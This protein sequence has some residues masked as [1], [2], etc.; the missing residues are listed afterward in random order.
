MD[1]QPIVD[2]IRSFVQSVDQTLTDRVKEV[3]SLYVQACNEVNQQLRRCEEFLQ[4]GLRSEAVHLAQT[5]PIL[6]DQLAI[7]DFAERP[8]WDELAMMY[9]LPVSP[10]LRVETAAALNEAYA[11]E[12]PLEELLHKHRLLALSRGS[13]KGRL[14]ILRRI[15]ELDPPN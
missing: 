11:D 3:A 6:L 4:K 8:Q 7:L 2:E 9:G 10:Q 1:Y 15:A 14:S 12:Q 5:E 13:L